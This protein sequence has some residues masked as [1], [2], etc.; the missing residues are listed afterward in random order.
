MG[1]LCLMRFGSNLERTQ[2]VAKAGL[3]WYGGPVPDAFW[4]QLTTHP[5]CG[6]CYTQAMCQMR[7]GS[8]F[9]RTQFVADSQCM[10]D[11]ALC[12]LCFGNALK[13]TQCV[14]DTLANLHVHFATQKRAKTDVIYS[15][16]LAKTGKRRSPDAFWRCPK[17]VKPLRSVLCV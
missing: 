14:A 3:A 16:R 8:T 1:A 12:L 7:F 11:G 17:I 10:G 15:V 2:V 6:W 5:V 4:E 9:K 13:R